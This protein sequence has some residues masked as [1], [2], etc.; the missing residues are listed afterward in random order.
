MAE[1]KDPE[2][3]SV[4]ANAAIMAV[5]L[6]P[7]LLGDVE[8]PLSLC[9]GLVTLFYRKR[10]CFNKNKLIIQT[11]KGCTAPESSEGR[12]ELRTVHK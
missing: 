9:D 2:T 3:L 5:G 7:S 12:L 4:K 10:N 1:A 11:L 8:T 6:I